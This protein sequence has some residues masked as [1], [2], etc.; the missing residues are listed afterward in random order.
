MSAYLT[1]RPLIACDGRIIA[2]LHVLPGKYDLL[3][4][5]LMDEAARGCAKIPGLAPFSQA[6]IHLRHRGNKLYR[7]QKSTLRSK[8]M[9]ECL[10]GYIFDQCKQQGSGLNSAALK[11]VHAGIY[12]AF[13]GTSLQD[14]IAEVWSEESS[15]ALR[16]AAD[17]MTED[18]VYRILAQLFEKL[19]RYLEP[20]AW[21]L[22]LA[23][24]FKGIL[25]LKD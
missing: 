25:R 11:K 10:S 24:I 3:Q 20:S 5:E 18:S 15:L 9:Q 14:R 23:D 8:P 13:I 4:A 7:A 21:H 16:Q 1:L 12:H 17:G 22:S 19:K 6:R 2:F